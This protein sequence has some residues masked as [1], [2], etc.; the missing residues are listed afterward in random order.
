MDAADERPATRVGPA[1]PTGPLPRHPA[2]TT[3]AISSAVAIMVFDVP[4]LARPGI[5]G[6]A[7]DSAAS[8]GA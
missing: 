1:L 7:A 5:A 8:S 6:G 2:G 3:I 4:P